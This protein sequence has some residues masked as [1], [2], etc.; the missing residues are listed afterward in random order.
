MNFAA[1]R[2]SLLWLA[3]LCSL[4][5]C[6]A[7]KQPPRLDADAAGFQAMIKD[8][9][10]AGIP[11][12]KTSVEAGD[13]FPE[14]KWDVLAVSGYMCPDPYSGLPGWRKWSLGSTG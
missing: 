8:A 2:F 4:A 14:K 12:H 7:P 5:S 1:Q 6:T 11:V 3:V 10:Q 9:S 13:F